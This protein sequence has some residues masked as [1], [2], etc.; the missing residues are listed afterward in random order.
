MNEYIE[1]YH[2]QHPR[3]KI[4]QKYFDILYDKCLNKGLIMCPKER[5][6]FNS[7]TDWAS[8]PIYEEIKSHPENKE[9]LSA[10]LWDAFSTFS[11]K[12]VGNPNTDWYIDKRKDFLSLEE[13]IKVVK[14]SEGLVFL[15]H[16]FVYKWSDDKKKL[17]DDI[18][19]NYDIDGIECMHSEFNQE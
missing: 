2:E 18:V 17:L 14:N 9:K 4:Q 6:D 1:K 7:K 8:I 13:A 16:I 19:N 12:Y 10:D 11:K 15:P 3:E 5:I